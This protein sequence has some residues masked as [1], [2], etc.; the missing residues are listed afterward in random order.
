MYR[1]CDFNNLHKLNPC[2]IE[3]TE[4]IRKVH[5]YIIKKLQFLES[6][7]IHIISEEKGLTVL[8]VVVSGVNQIKDITSDMLREF[9]QKDC[10][11]EKIEIDTGKINEYTH[12]DIECGKRKLI[13]IDYMYDDSVCEERKFYR[14]EN[15]GEYS[16]RK[17]D[18]TVCA[19]DELVPPPDFITRYS[20]VYLINKDKCNIKINH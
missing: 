19:G 14:V 11:L 20:K 6:T 16:E 9:D 17:Y 15:N 4:C 10:P 7:G 13:Q 12:G 3:D 5:S 18:P 2:L 1:M 8:K